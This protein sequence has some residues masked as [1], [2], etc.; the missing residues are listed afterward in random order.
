[1]ASPWVGCW[2]RA[3][4]ETHLRSVLISDIAHA[5]IAANHPHFG[6]FQN[7]LVGHQRIGE[8]GKF[9]ILTRIDDVFGPLQEDIGQPFGDHGPD[10]VT[11]CQRTRSPWRRLRAWL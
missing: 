7:L 2:V 5:A 1:M 9:I 10:S 8:M 11:R 4:S 3:S 6:K